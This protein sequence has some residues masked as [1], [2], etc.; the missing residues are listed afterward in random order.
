MPGVLVSPHM[1]GETTGEWEALVEVFFDNLT[2]HIEGRPL[3]NVVD[4]AAETW[5]TPTHYVCEGG[6][7][8]GKH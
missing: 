4:K 5:W 6:T 7:F 3:R 8:P 1:A 2:R